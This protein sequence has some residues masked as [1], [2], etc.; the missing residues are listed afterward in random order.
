M[1]PKHKEI[2]KNH[3]Y[4]DYAFGEITS[5][6]ALLESTFSQDV[7]SIVDLGAGRGALCFELCVLTKANIIGYEIAEW[8]FDTACNAYSTISKL[9]P[10]IAY[11]EKKDTSATIIAWGQHLCLHRAS[12]LSDSAHEHVKKADLVIADL[13]IPPGMSSKYVQL[14]HDMKPGARLLTFHYLSDLHSHFTLAFPLELATT[15][16]ANHTHRFFLRVRLS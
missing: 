11:F 5:G 2:P 4:V 10:D 9:W 1:G 7:N 15:W 14:F 16:G 12:A 6:D 8:A 13:S 3:E